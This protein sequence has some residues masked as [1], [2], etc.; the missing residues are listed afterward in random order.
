MDSVLK[1][2]PA[3]KYSSDDMIMSESLIDDDTGTWY[4]VCGRNDTS[5]M[6]I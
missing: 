1:G 5:T 4:L 2:T 6:K 3:R